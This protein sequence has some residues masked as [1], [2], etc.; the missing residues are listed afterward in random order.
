M[1]TAALHEAVKGIR[2]WAMGDGRNIQTPKPMHDLFVDDDQGKIVKGHPV[3]QE[4]MR[5]DDDA[6]FTGEDLQQG[7]LT[8]R[9]SLGSGEQGDSRRVS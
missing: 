5:A 9:R 1:S 3:L 8:V 4:R 2:S 7:P 6:R